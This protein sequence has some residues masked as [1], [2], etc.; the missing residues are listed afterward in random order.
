MA[1]SIPLGEHAE[2]TA[3]RP[4]GVG[5]R[6]AFGL[7]QPPASVVGPVAALDSS[8]LAGF[9]CAEFLTPRERQESL[10]FRA[11]GRKSEWLAARLASKF[12]FLT[13]QSG[14][15]DASDLLRFPPATYR[16][17]E[18]TRDDRIRFG[19]PQVCRGNEC[20]DVAISHAN[21]VACVLLGE[22]KPGERETIAVDVERVEARTPVFYR[23]NFTA[24]ETARAEEY[25][26][27]VGLNPA[28]TLTLLWSIKECLLKT[29]AYNDLSVW[30]MP[31]IDLRI[32]SGGDDLLRVHS[33]PACLSEFVFLNVEATSR[34]GTDLRRVAVSGWHDERTGRRSV[35]REVESWVITVI[36]GGD[37]RTV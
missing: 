10:R 37:R 7:F 31:F 18:V 27:R 32:V 17:V 9:D 36:R 26:R 14:T 19:L 1:A 3:L 8:V 25:S 6:P 34:R 13:E 20:R 5:L 16:S 22:G 15:V 23:G 33:N 35:V 2:A 29:R 12:L 4:C 28:W 21:G 24:G 11:P 30:D